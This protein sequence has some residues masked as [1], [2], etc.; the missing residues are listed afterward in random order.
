MLCKDLVGYVLEYGLIWYTGM[1]RTH[2]LRLKKVQY[3]GIRIAL[4]FDPGSLR[5]LSGMAS[6][7]K[8]FVYLNIR[9]L[10]RF[11]NRLDYLLKKKLETLEELNMSRCIAGYSDVF[12]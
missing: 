1:A 4:G 2:M 7:A 9:F 6:I 10:W 12:H 8:R 11:S 3:R 5:V